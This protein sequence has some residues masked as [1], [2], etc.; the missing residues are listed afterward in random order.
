[1]VGTGDARVKSTGIEVPTV[2]NLVAVL[3]FA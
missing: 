2:M 1:M 3:S